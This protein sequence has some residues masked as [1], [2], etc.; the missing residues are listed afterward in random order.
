MLM[1]VHLKTNFIHALH[2]PEVKFAHGKRNPIMN[3]IEFV[4]VTV[5][6]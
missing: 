2:A 6:I 4:F 3:I 5:Y 1:F